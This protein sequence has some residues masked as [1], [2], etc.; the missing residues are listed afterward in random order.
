M[1]KDLLHTL[2]EKNSFYAHPDQKDTLRIHEWR[3]TGCILKRY[4]P[5]YYVSA[6]KRKVCLGGSSI[7]H[8]TTPVCTSLTAIRGAH[9]RASQKR[10]SWYLPDSKACKVFQKFREW[11]AW[12]CERINGSSFQTVAVARDRSCRFFLFHWQ[13]TSATAVSKPSLVFS[14]RQVST[15]IVHRCTTA[16]IYFNECEYLCSSF[17]RARLKFLENSKTF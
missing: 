1:K 16:A 7:Q 4:F 12:R 9:F 10:E 11:N 8:D 2:F 5:G 6:K 17:Q 3:V 14:E 13:W 15:R